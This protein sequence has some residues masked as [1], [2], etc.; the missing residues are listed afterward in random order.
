MDNEMKIVKKIK[1]RFDE[2]RLQHSLGVAKVAVDLAVREGKSQKK[3]RIAG[4]LHDY[5]KGLRRNKLVNFAKQDDWQ[6]DETE[7][8]LTSVLHAPAGVYMVKRDFG[9]TDK[10][11]LEA[12]RYHTIGN[13]EMGKLAQI[14]FVAD[15]VEPNRN[16]PGVARIRSQLANNGLIPAI[17]TVC[18]YSINYNI[19]KGCL[20]H[21]DT[22]LLRNALLGGNR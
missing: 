21:P 17:I 4:L 7:L 20:I 8:L 3:A 15:I 19:E 13:P 18:N 12:I 2:D 5:A 14:I 16:F 11:I 22:L 10:E 9:L 1:E 6:L